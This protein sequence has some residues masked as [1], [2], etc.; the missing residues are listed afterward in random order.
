VLA[1]FVS[2]R[3]G[4][5]CFGAFFFK[6]SEVGVRQGNSTQ[7]SFVVADFWRTCLASTSSPLFLSFLFEHESGFVCSNMD[8]VV[9]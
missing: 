9:I 6:A 1:L 7:S 3:F 4:E 2:G 8:G 5:F